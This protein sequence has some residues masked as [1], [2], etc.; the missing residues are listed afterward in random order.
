[1][2]TPL[3][4]A[5]QPVNPDLF[6]RLARF[7]QLLQRD[8][9]KQAGDLVE[10][11]SSEG[12]STNETARDEVKHLC[13]GGEFTVLEAVLGAV[14]ALGKRRRELTYNSP[15]SGAFLPGGSEVYLRPRGHAAALRLNVGSSYTS[16]IA[17]GAWRAV[18][19]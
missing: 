14:L 11:V 13:L 4:S 5:V 9:D 3:S 12:V 19:R 1:V 2:S 7:Q 17:M 10:G 16:G 6:Y 18:E 15:R 8:P